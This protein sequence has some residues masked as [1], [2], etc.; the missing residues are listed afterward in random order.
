MWVYFTFPPS[1]NIPVESLNSLKFT[2]V[3]K[4]TLGKE[5]DAVIGKV[6]VREDSSSMR[7]GVRGLQRNQVRRIRGIIPG[8][9]QGS[10]SSKIPTMGKLL[11]RSGGIFSLKT[12]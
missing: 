12:I 8:L 6:L 11:M 9:I 5:E 1:A 7:I 2:L 4:G 10:I 3:Y